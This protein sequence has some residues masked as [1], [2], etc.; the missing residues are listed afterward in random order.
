MEGASRGARRP[1]GRASTWAG[2][3]V[4][5]GQALLGA[6]TRPARPSSRAPGPEGHICT[7][8]DGSEA[9]SPAAPGGLP[10]DCR[11]QASCHTFLQ[12]RPGLRQPRVAQQLWIHLKLQGQH[13]SAGRQPR[14]GCSNAWVSGRSQRPLHGPGPWASPGLAGLPLLSSQL[15]HL[16]APSQ[17]SSAAIF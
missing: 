8:T 13:F 5:T 1:P 9:P 11:P 3:Q 16:A 10:A 12:A 7:G 14:V 4:C 17:H 6:G 15:L 2:P